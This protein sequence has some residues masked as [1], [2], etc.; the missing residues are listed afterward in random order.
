MSTSGQRVTR[1]LEW[2]A[3]LPA[4]LRPTRQDV[5][6]AARLRVTQ[7]PVMVR[8]LWEDQ[9]ALGRYFADLAAIVSA[10]VTGAVETPVQKVIPTPPAQ[11]P[12]A[13][14]APASFFDLES[15]IKGL[16]DRGHE[17]P[18][19]DGLAAKLQEL[20]TEDELHRVTVTARDRRKWR[21]FLRQYGS[22]LGSVLGLE[23]SENP[24][25]SATAPSP[26]HST[27]V[28]SRE[29]FTG[30]IEVRY[31]SS[32]PRRMSFPPSETAG[33][34][35]TWEAPP[36]DGQV[37][38]YRVVARPDTTPWDLDLGERGRLV[39][40]TF[41]KSALDDEPLTG[42]RRFYAVFVN[43]GPTEAEAR[44]SQPELWA[45]GTAI[46]PV[47]SAQISSS[48]RRVSGRW[49]VSSE[50]DR[51]EIL[52]V[53]VQDP[54]VSTGVYD[55]DFLISGHERGENLDGFADEDVPSG[56]WEYR[57]YACAEVNGTTERSSVVTS[58]QTIATELPVVRDLRVDIINGDRFVISW[59]PLADPALSVRIHKRLDPPPPELADRTIDGANLA[60]NG[61][62]ANTAITDPERLL[63]GRAQ[64]E[65]TWLRGE[66]RVYFTAI[67]VPKNTD[68]YRVGQP[69]V[70][71]RA[72]EVRHVQLVE[73]VDE[74]FLSFAWP[75]GAG[76]VKVYQG[77]SDQGVDPSDLS[78]LPEVA[79]LTP[80]M[81]RQRGGLHLRPL[82]AEGAVLYVVGLS[83]NDGR[84][85]Q[86]PP[87][88][89]LYPGLVRIEYSVGSE[90][91]QVR[92]GF[93]KVEQESA[94]YIDVR[95]N[96]DVS[97]ALVLVRNAERLPLHQH[98][99][100]PGSSGV[101]RLQRGLPH[102]LTTIEPGTIQG[103]LRLFVDVP[104]L[105]QEKYAIT[106]PPLSQLRWS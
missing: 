68:Q 54:P 94:H 17:V 1:A 63:E 69:V 5:E 11:T 82:P 35:L 38:I 45:E 60:R 91:R 76:I 90:T 47:H 61:F 22:E 40:S 19:D 27:G 74:Q 101:V 106:D 9:P 16:R 100:E 44:A 6:V 10:D 29:G 65:S 46:P 89:V 104:D 12:R 67:T 55:T 88:I 2:W 53:P 36:E 64:V 72:G 73:R 50:I 15:W 48:G 87:A 8:M 62:T 3:T 59:T 77:N 49:T 97:V 103:F 37:R 25:S 92:Q 24:P 84:P 18:I 86:G 105:Q 58:T 96:V 26:V 41:D 71:N 80:E 31:T 30:G 7:L 79:E 4:D 23:P 66:D 52:R 32:V 75:D 14:T 83:F 85:T 39:A 33:N 56:R 13:P 102:R 95:A 21:D 93:R 43:T 70:C 99:G 42:A 51:V 98:D 34:L 78:A 57:L 20:E 81:H 28:T